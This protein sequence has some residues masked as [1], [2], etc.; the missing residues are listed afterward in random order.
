MDNQ[1]VLS[2]SDIFNVINDRLPKNVTYSTIYSVLG[3]KVEFS[4]DEVDLI[5]QEISKV[6]QTKQNKINQRACAL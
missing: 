5:I 3:K 4:E 6:H 2:V 1:I